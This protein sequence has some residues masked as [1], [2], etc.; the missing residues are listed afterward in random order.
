M[1]YPNSPSAIPAPSRSGTLCTFGAVRRHA[2]H[3]TRQ[4]SARW[5]CSRPQVQRM[6]NTLTARVQRTATM[7][8][9]GVTV[10]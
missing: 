1:G 4:R 8:S 6:R 10:V 7:S 3:V 2:G 5:S 9:G